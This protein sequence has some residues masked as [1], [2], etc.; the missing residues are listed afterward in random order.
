[1][2]GAFVEVIGPTGDRTPFGPEVSLAL[3]A[4]GGALRK[5]NDADVSGPVVF[6]MNSESK[7]IEIRT[8]LGG[9]LET[10]AIEILDP[11][12]LQPLTFTVENHIIIISF[13]GRNSL[14]TPIRIQQ[15]S[16]D[17]DV[18]DVIA[19]TSEAC[20]EPDVSQPPLYDKASDDSTVSDLTL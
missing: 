12:Q 4:E 17:D 15:R 6:Q 20:Q 13:S 9:Q 7:S 18:E 8:P 10:Q 19:S 14:D 1:V 11:I 2:S 16:P 3:V 5:V